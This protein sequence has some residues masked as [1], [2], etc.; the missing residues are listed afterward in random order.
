MYKNSIILLLL[1]LVN[2]IN[3]KQI[4]NV[5]NHY[6]TKIILHDEGF[7][8]IP[9]ISYNVN[10]LINIIPII[11]IIYSI[12]KLNNKFVEITSTIIVMII[13]RV[14]ANRST[15][16]PYSDEKCK[17]VSILGGC[18]DKMFSGHM[19]LTALLCLFYYEE[20]KNIYISIVLIIMQM[21]LLISTRSHYTIDV[22]IGFLIALLIYTNKNKI[23]M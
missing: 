10:T 12:L 3:T 5:A 14:I 20:S 16:L 21:F 15:I 7:K 22:Y 9:R 1:I 18:H 23:I 4:D 6:K 2:Y 13:L 19:A 11:L 8:L 17:G